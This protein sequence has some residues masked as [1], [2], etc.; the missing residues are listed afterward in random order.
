MQNNKIFVVCP[1]NKTTGGPELLHQLC[2]EL[3]S[4]GYDALMLYYGFDEKKFSQPVASRYIFYKNPYTMDFV[5][6][7][8]DW[9]VLPETQPNFLRQIKK[10]HKIF[11]WLSVDNFYR[12]IYCFIENE[13]TNN[14]LEYLQKVVRFAGDL[15]CEDVIHFV[16]SEYAMAHCRRIGIQ[17]TKLFYLS[18]YLHPSFVERAVGQR[19]VKENVV[20]YN[21]QRGYAFTKCLIETAPHI[22]WVPLQGFS[23]DQMAEVLGKAKVYIDFGNHPGKDRIPREAAISGCCVLT[24]TKGSAGYAEDIPIPSEYKFDDKIENCMD[25][26]GKIEDIF[27]DYEKHS[28]NFAEYRKSIL[29]EKKRFQNTVGE[30]FSRIIHPSRVEADVITVQ[31]TSNPLLSAAEARLR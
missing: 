24:G 29:G 5:D 26:L 22:R 7:I 30:L 9:F 23:A 20:L 6:R 16:Q 4:Q 31:K 10:A 25:I 21:P 8:G 15:H 3:R 14:G 27:S 17:E 2:H 18:D 28:A 19:F 11:W 12:A 1:A 13:H